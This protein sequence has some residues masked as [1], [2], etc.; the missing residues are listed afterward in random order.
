MASKETRQKELKRIYDRD[1]EV[2]ASIVV[3]EATPKKSPLHSEFEW[4]DKK[5]AH[6][7]RVSTA[8]R[9][10]K[11]TRIVSNEGVRQ[12]LVHVPALIVQGP[13]AASNEREGSYKTIT[14]VAAN[15][16]EYHR[17]L[18]QLQ[19]QVSTI[20]VMIR[21]L[22]QAKAGEPDELLPALEDA[23]NVAKSTVRL[24]ARLGWARRGSARHG[25][26]GMAG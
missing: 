8:R 9:I 19:T 26:Q 17:A 24:M 1:G 20:Q 25:R 14:E 21:A 12:R 4:D 18:R 3:M 5:A 16:G 11:V 6:Q 13:T 2:R 23:M 10:I 22:K 7:H 15:E